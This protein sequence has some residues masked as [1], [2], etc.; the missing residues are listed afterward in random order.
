MKFTIVGP[1]DQELTD[2]KNGWV[3]WLQTMKRTSGESRELRRRIEEFSNGVSGDSP[4][5]LRD[6]NGI[7]DYK[8]VTPPNVA[9]LMFMVEEGTG[10]NLKR[11]LLT[12]TRT[13]GQDPARSAPDPLSGGPGLHLD[14]LKVQ[15]HGSENNLDADFARH[16]SARNYVFCGDGLHGNPNTGVIDLIF[17]SRRG[18]RP[19]GRAGGRQRGVPLW[20]STT[21]GNQDDANGRRRS[22]KWKITSK[23]SAVGAGLLRPLQ[24]SGID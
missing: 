19:S 18:R 20:F 5:D 11:L 22:G 16:V 1:T 14:V 17:Q 21:S 9:S 15:H 10:A 2:L 24:R 12:V 6:W 3:T 23:V 7:P 4:F 13:P 8:G